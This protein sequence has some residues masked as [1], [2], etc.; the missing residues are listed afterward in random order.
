LPAPAQLKTTK[1]FFTSHRRVKAVL[2][3][4][5]SGR[6]DTIINAII[7]PYCA[8]DKE[9]IN[10][11]T[12]ADEHKKTENLVVWRAAPKFCATI[13]RIV[14]NAEKTQFYSALL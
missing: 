8:A 5:S 13:E 9:F 2:P 11:R 10:V 12:Y 3:C 4:L 6:A 1:N 14:Q 7:V